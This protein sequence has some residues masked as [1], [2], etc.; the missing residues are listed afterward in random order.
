LHLPPWLCCLAVALYASLPLTV[1]AMTGMQTEGPTTALVAGI[2]LLIQRS[3]KPDRR[4]LLA[5]AVLFGLLLA[6]KVSNL[7]IAGPL[8]LWLL[9]LWR[10][11]LPWS[12]LPVALLL[13]L[14]VAGS[15]YTYGWLLTGNP[16]LPVF[17]AI[18][19]SPY[20]TPT[21]FH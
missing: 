19:R 8:G 15:S 14:L 20:Y 1:G 6:M 4:Q 17:N 3:S 12:T 13:L 21:N 10:A 5:F 7:M 2:A 16:V 9:C 18:F 11:R